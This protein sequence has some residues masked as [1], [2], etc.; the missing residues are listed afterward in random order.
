MK[1]V[2]EKIVERGYAGDEA[3]DT[4]AQEV[5]NML[6][7]VSAQSLLELAER[8]QG[9][10]ALGARREY[11]L[12][13]TYGSTGSSLGDLQKPVKESK[14]YLGGGSLSSLRSRFWA[15]IETDI[16]RAGGH[17]GRSF[18]FLFESIFCRRR[19]GPVFF[20]SG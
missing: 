15:L 7:V 18:W 16:A 4:D 1:E 11:S 19:H 10:L 14:R 8:G 5:S 3:E 9:E 20:G 13:G 6:R 12:L 17:V 2:I